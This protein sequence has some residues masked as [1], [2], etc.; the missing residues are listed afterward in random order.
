MKRLSGAKGL[1]RQV[2]DKWNFKIRRTSKWKDRRYLV[3]FPG[4]GWFEYWGGDSPLGQMLRK[5]PP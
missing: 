4:R 1:R 3:E 2:L 5:H